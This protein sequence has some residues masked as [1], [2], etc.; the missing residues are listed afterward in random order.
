MADKSFLK[1]LIIDP[2]F[3]SDAVKAMKKQ[4][5][6]ISGSFLEGISQGF[7]TNKNIKDSARSF[8]RS[9]AD[10]IISQLKEGWEEI[11]NMLKFTTFSNAEYRNLAFT[12]GMSGSQAYGYSKASEITGLDVDSLMW[13]TPQERQKFQEYMNKYNQKYSELYDSGFFE[14][15]REFNYEMEDFKQEMTSEVVEFF[16]DN[17]DTIKQGM[18][19]VMKIADWLL[20]AGGKILD[21]FAF[22]HNSA[23]TSDI[24]NNAGGSRYNNTTVKIDNTFNNVAQNDQTWLANAGQMTYQQVLEVLKA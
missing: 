22:G 4:V 24:I 12:Y 23:S 15:L 2:I 17:K 7:G 6:D 16:M 8:G 3:N 13:A 9:I 21:F 18:L 11:N 10:G 5:K 20:N 14:E 1:T 19:A